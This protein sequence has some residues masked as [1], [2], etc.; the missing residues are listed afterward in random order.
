MIV[1]DASSVSFLNCRCYRRCISP[2]ALF[3]CSKMDPRR[4]IWMRSTKLNV[5]MFGL[6][7][8]G[9]RMRSRYLLRPTDTRAQIRVVQ[10]RHEAAGWQ[11]YR[12]SVSGANCTFVAL[13]M[14][15]ILRSR[16]P[17]DTR[18]FV[19]FLPLR[20]YS[21][22]RVSN[23]IHNWPENR[24]IRKLVSQ[25]HSFSLDRRRRRRTAIP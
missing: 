25:S 13:W 16:C 11:S 6:S 3:Y 19:R 7:G 2:A 4:Q 9:D 12:R 17:R 1:N 21:L 24:R 18:W 15:A 20:F 23:H 22:R 5:L 8:A 10:N 14:L